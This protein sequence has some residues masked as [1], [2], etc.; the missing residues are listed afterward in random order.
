MGPAMIGGATVAK[1]SDSPGVV[2]APSI[3]SADF[4]RLGEEVDAVNKGGADWIHIDVMDGCSFR[5]LRSAPSL[6]RQSADRRN[7]RPM[8]I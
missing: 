4:R 3:L 5:T 1:T 2:I 7:C 8:C 6:L